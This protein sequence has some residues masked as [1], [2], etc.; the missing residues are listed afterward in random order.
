MGESLKPEHTRILVE[1]LTEDGLVYCFTWE[2]QD[3]DE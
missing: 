3:E 1:E 2:F